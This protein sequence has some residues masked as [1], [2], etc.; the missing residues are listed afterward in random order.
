[1]KRSIVHCYFI[2]FEFVKGARK[3]LLKEYR[4]DAKTRH[5]STYSEKSYINDMRIELMY[6]YVLSARDY[7]CVGGFPINVH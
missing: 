5:L 7:I 4:L 3:S 6:E 1:M 2:E